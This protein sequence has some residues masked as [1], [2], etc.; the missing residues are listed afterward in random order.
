MNKILLIITVMSSFFSAK[1]QQDNTI[2]ILT[3]S[4]FNE[5]INN[6]DVQLVDV[7]T[8]KEFNDGAIKNALNIDFFQQEIFNEEFGKLNKEQPVYLY[9]RSGNRS[10]QAALKLEAMGFKEI[11]D[12]KGGYMGWPDKK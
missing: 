6:N 2:K 9:C 1:A 7:R 4:E 10:H 5:G 11:Y 3:A 12:L 8:A